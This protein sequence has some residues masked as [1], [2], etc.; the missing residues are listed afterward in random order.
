MRHYSL[1]PRLGAFFC[2]LT[3]LVGNLLGRIFI[4]LAYV[5][6]LSSSSAFTSWWWGAK[7]VTAKLRREAFDLRLALGTML[8][9]LLFANETLEEGDGPSGGD[10]NRQDRSDP[11]RVSGQKRQVCCLACA[12]L[13]L[14]TTHLIIPRWQ[15]HMVPSRL[16]KLAAAL[17]QLDDADDADSITSLSKMSL[18][19]MTAQIR[20]IE[21]RALNLAQDE[22][23]EEFRVKLL[24]QNLLYQ[25]Q[26]GQGA[27]A[28][29]AASSRPE[30]LPSASD[31]TTA[32]EEAS[33]LSPLLEVPAVSA[34]PLNIRVVPSGDLAQARKRQATGTGGGLTFAPFESGNNL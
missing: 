32:R 6:R 31:R 13:W 25:N 4:L 5:N 23:N 30:P 3:H 18:P 29:E 24:L 33:K 7:H 27:Y 12:W 19:Q 15:R 2:G 21:Q 20:N 22:S 9:D 1:A 26:P 16:V 10:A 14:R 28:A 34:C 11:E 17:K 8:E